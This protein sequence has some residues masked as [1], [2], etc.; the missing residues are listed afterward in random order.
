M[1]FA[2]TSIRAS[3]SGGGMGVFS[4]IW[5]LEV[6]SQHLGQAKLAVY[7]YF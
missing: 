3:Q 5:S 4:E 6:R 7:P 1:S 2:M